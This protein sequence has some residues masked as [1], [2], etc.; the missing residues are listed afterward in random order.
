MTDP[1]PVRDAVTRGAERLVAELV[2]WLRIPSI[3]GDPQNAG[4]VRRSAGVSL[5]DDGWH[6]PNEK[7]E[8][9]LLFKGA[10]PTA[11]LWDELAAT[12]RT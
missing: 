9:P 7:V 4:D 1:P 8:I 5:P 2:E 3:S 12:L 6:A 11:H 10:E